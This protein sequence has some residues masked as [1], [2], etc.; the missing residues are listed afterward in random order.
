[1]KAC[2]IDIASSF[3]EFVFRFLDRCACALFGLDSVGSDSG[4]RDRQGRHCGFAPQW[5]V[6]LDSG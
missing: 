5:N 2:P 3:R 4:R 6:L 1:M